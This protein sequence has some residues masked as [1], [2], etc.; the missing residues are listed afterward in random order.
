MSALLGGICLRMLILFMQVQGDLGAHAA[1]ELTLQRLEDRFRQDV[2]LAQSVVLDQSSEAKILRF[3]DSAGHT[4]EYAFKSGEVQRTLPEAPASQEFDTFLLPQC[5]AEA[6]L[7]LPLVSLRVTSVSRQG[8]TPIVQRI[9]AL[10]EQPGAL[11]T[12]VVP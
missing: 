4:I 10:M 7:E 8:G 11:S 1:R 6:S 5:T 9:E 12:E 2:H 3:V